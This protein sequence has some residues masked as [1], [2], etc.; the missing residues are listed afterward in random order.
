MTPMIAEIIPGT[1]ITVGAGLMKYSPEVF[2]PQ[3]G[4]LNIDR[5][6]QELGYRPQY[7]R[8]SKA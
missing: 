8:F 4:A 2:A 5:A 6:G 7:A 1:D 3:K